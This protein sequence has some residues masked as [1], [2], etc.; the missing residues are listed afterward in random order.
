MKSRW[1][2]SIPFTFTKPG[3]KIRVE[4]LY[5]LQTFSNLRAG[6]P[7]VRKQKILKL[8]NTLWYMVCGQC[9]ICRLGSVRDGRWTVKD[10]C[11]PGRLPDPPHHPLS[12]VPKVT[13]PI[14]Q[15]ATDKRNLWSQIVRRIISDIN[16]LFI[17]KTFND[18]HFHCTVNVKE[19]RVWTFVSRCICFLGIGAI[20][21]LGDRLHQAMG[22]K[23]VPGPG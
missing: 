8:I 15:P 23:I 5:F 4:S 22:A 20:S 17:C 12:L 19:N 21:P 9:N 16:C 6:W 3:P 13:A 2:I 18:I 10:M 11:S 1:L 7:L 14:R